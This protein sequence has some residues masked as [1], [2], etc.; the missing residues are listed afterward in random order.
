[1]SN[2]D[3]EVEQLTSQVS[4]LMKHCRQLED[5]LRQMRA[6]YITDIANL[7]EAHRVEVEGLKA[8]IT[9][10]EQENTLLKNDNERL[11]SNARNN[12]KNSSLPPSSDQ[13]AGKKANEYNGREKSG[14]KPGGQEGHKGRTL[15][16]EYVEEKIR[17]GKF[18]HKV[19]DIGDESA[20]Y[21]VRYVLDVKVV[22]VVTEIRIHANADGKYEVPEG[23]KSGVTYGDNIKAIAV[24]LYGEGVVSHDRIA[25]FIASLT[26]GEIP[27]SVGSIYNFCREMAW[28]GEGSIAQIK[29]ELLNERVIYTDATTIMVNGTQEYI[30]NQS[31]HGAVLYSPVEKKN[32]EALKSTGILGKY[33]GITVNDHETA[34]YHVGTDT[35]ECNAHLL[36]YGRKNTEE[37]GNSWSEKLSKHLCDV[38]GKKKEL[39]L[40]GI[41][42]F[43]EEYLAEISRKYDEIIMKGKEENSRTSGVQ[44]Q[45]EEKALLNRLVRYKHNHLLFAYDFDVEFTN[46]MSER[47]LRKCKN[48]Q[49]MSGGFRKKSGKAIYCDILS[50]IE[51][52]KR[53][54]IP[55]FDSIRQIFAGNPNIF[56]NTSPSPA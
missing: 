41:H 42:A 9:E 29:E 36:R 21:I 51:T 16:R 26:N 12:S 33:S 50:L 32:I 53:K 6:S 18:Q 23:Y 19:V 4:K 46:N 8:R 35:G 49:K 17:E 47:D 37:T 11:K 44:A 31:T 40:K 43:S 13:K 52:C 48:R 38:N 20:N 28:K 45:K 22:P 15:S 55:V 7:K 25:A 24:D 54:S 5:E 30:R 56:Q 34:L 10:L 27:L 14:K 1:M 39:I 2:R 3:R